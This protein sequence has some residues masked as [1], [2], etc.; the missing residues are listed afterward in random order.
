MPL[1]LFELKLEYSPIPQA[2]DV[3]FD[4]AEALVRS[5]RISALR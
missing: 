4:Q 1:E 2:M 3:Y 5:G